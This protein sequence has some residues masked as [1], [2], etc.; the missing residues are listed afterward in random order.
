MENRENLRERTGFLIQIWYQLFTCDIL[1]L[2]L[3]Y[4]T[5]SFKNDSYDMYISFFR[6]LQDYIKRPDSYYE[7]VWN[8][9]EI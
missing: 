9:K 3:I 2:E 8:K 7:K 4:Q 5:I 6:E 1:L